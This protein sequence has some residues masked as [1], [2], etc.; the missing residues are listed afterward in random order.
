MRLGQTTSIFGR[1]TTIVIAVV[2]AVALGLQSAQAAGLLQGRGVSVQDAAIR[3]AARKA[4]PHVERGFQ[5][6]SAAWR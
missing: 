1:G 3:E 2:M 6:Y 4:G 5:A